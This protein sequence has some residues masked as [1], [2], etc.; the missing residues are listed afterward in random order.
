[1]ASVL[2]KYMPPIPHPPDLEKGRYTCPRLNTSTRLCLQPSLVTLP[3][4]YLQSLPIQS[5][6]ASRGKTST[7]LPV[8]GKKKAFFTVISASHQPLLRSLLCQAPW[9]NNCLPQPSIVQFPPRHPLKHL[10]SQWPL[11]KGALAYFLSLLTIFSPVATGRP[12]P[13][14]APL[15]VLHSFLSPLCTFPH[16]PHST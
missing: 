5:F 4:L 6:L 2:R 8:K 11:T 14:L 1:M 9:K 3:L 10:Q 13:A 7:V 12:S 16:K 15:K